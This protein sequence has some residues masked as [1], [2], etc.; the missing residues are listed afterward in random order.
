VYPQ[1]DAIETHFK[2]GRIWKTRFDINRSD[3]YDKLNRNLMNRLRKRE[4]ATPEEQLRFLD[5]DLVCDP[6]L[7]AD[8]S[9]KL[10]PERFDKFRRAVF[11]ERAPEIAPN[12]AVEVNY[13]RSHDC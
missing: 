10:T 4:D 5:I 2:C 7:L 11:G 12:V 1:H 9:S 8:S 6:P 3:G 13:Y